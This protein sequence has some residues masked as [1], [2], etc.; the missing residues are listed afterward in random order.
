MF[1]TKVILSMKKQVYIAQSILF[2]LFFCAVQMVEAQEPISQVR[3]E[4]IQSLEGVLL[5]GGDMDQFIEEKL[6]PTYRS[7]LPPN[8]MKDHLKT[9]SKAVSNAQALEINVEPDAVQLIFSEGASSTILVRFASGDSGL[10]EYI[11]FMEQK[12]YDEMTAS[13]RLSLAR[14]T[15]IRAIEALGRARDRQLDSFLDTHV[16]PTLLNTIDRSEMIA[17]LQALRKII[18]TSGVIMFDQTD[19]GSLLK[20]RGSENANVLLALDPAEPYLISS[21]MIDTKVDVSAEEQEKAA[22]APINWDNLDQRLEERNRSWLFRSRACCSQWEARPP[23]RVWACR[24]KFGAGKY[25]FNDLRH[26]I[27]SNRFHDCSSSKTRR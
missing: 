13:E 1:N 9:L 4:A 21:L 23:K 27:H 6:T 7:S 18:A 3:M 14:R 26:W 15:R 25:V 19:E 8:A 16:S 5:A 24:S 17:N 12:S 20:F 11:G 22:I 2:M 10:I